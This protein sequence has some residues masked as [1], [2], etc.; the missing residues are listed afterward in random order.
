MKVKLTLQEKLRDLRAEN[1]FKL[2]DVAEKTGISTTA[3]STY[4]NDELKE[5]QHTSIVALARLYGVSTDYLLGLSENRNTSMPLSEL[6]LPDKLAGFLKKK[7][8]NLL[9]LTEFVS[10]PSF[11]SLMADME[12]FVDG[13]ERINIQILNAL[14][15]KANEL[16]RQK[17]G[18][19][20]NLADSGEIIPPLRHIEDDAYFFNRIGSKLNEIV[21]DIRNAHTSDD[22][23]ASDDY[24][25]DLIDKNMENIQK[26][27]SK[28]KD[29]PRKRAAD[30]LFYIICQDLQVKPA[31][32]TIEE[33]AAI[34]KLIAR[35]GLYKT[36]SKRMR[37]TKRH[38]KKLS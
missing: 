11:P 3:L 38:K 18:F 21:R 34:A 6:D 22:E 33:K 1:R 8:V 35:S 32:L 2:S 19:E 13:L 29:D 23:T 9:L 15:D 14:A 20:P 24:L 16:I 28:A 10:H 26:L 37:R 25:S 17:Y 12:L 31:S 36:E 27:W 5:I 30:Y 7:N 4:E